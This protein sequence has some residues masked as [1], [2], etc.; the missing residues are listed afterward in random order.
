MIKDLKELEKLDMSKDK[1]LL[2]DLILQS[3]TDSYAQ[4]I[5]NIYMNKIQCT[6]A[7]L[8]NILVTTE[9]IL[10]SSRGSV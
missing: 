10:R 4:F 8:V 3:L 2:I 1:K 6:I 9:G 7:K 5:V